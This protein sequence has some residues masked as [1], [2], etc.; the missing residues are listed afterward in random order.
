MP[1]KGSC[2]YFCVVALDG[3]LIDAFVFFSFPLLPEGLK[4]EKSLSLLMN[5][6]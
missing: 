2:D 6:L 5:E 3:G 4:V 1:E